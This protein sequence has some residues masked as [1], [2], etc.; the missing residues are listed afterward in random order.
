MKD[1]LYFFDNIK[2]I[3]IFL[4]VFGHLIEPF[5]KI[6]KPYLVIYSIIYIFHMPLFAFVSGYFSK[7]PKKKEIYNLVKIFFAFEFIYAITMFLAIYFRPEQMKVLTGNPGILDSFLDNLFYV[8]SPIWLLWYILALISWKL[9][10]KVFKRSPWLIIV[11]IIMALLVGAIDIPGRAL[12]F[13]RTFIIFPFFLIGY[14]VNFDQVMKIKNS[15]F[16]KILTLLTIAISFYII[17]MFVEIGPKMLYFADNYNELDMTFTTGIITRSLLLLYV[18]MFC[19]SVIV[20]TSNKKQ[21]YSYIGKHTIGIYLLHGIVIV[22]FLSLGAVTYLMQFNF[23]VN[24]IVCILMSIF[25]CY[26]F[27]KEQVTQKI[28]LITLQKGKKEKDDRI[29]T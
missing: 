21:L 25:I 13:Q 7:I 22:L 27:G 12:S 28:L 8:L 29:S 24:V 20:L 16:S 15:I 5:I 9:L 4:V 18:A 10:L 19:I 17:P 3:L 2:V 26:I 23:V 11:A 14:Y 6:Q 1:R